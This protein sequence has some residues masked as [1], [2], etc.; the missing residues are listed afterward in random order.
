MSEKRPGLPRLSVLGPVLAFAAG[1]LALLPVLGNGFVD[2]DDPVY[3]VKN[4]AFRG[5]APHQ[6]AW[7]FTNTLQCVYQPLAWLTL[8]ADYKVWGM[9]PGGFHL[10]ALL[11][12]ALTAAVF[13]RLALRLLERSRGASPANAAGALVAALLFAVHP[14]RAE[15]VAWA[16]ERR[17]LV[18][19]LFWLLA[20][21]LYVGPARRKGRPPLRG[22]LACF[23]L[24]LLA[25]GTM[26][27][28]P[29]VLLALDFY[30]LRRLGSR[31][32]A[33]EALVEK[34]PFFAL[35]LVF[36]AIGLW[37]VTTQGEVGLGLQVW[38]L[39]ERAAQ[40]FYGL[41]FYAAKTLW[42]ARL[43][44]LY[45]MPRRFSPLSPVFLASY[46]SV[47]AAAA[48][49]F[50]LRRRFPAWTA[51]CAAYAATLLPVIGVVKYGPHITAD[52][53]SNLS[54]LGLLVLVGALFAWALERAKGRAAAAAVWSLP[55]S[56]ALV[57]GLQARRQASYWRDS[58]TLWRRAL[59]LDPLNAGAHDNLGVAAADEGRL[60]EAAA[61][62]R[63]AIA[64]DPDLLG[65]YENLAAVLSR[66]GRWEDAAA[67][68]EEEIRRAP[69]R[70][71]A[72]AR[73]ALAYVRA[74]RTRE[75]ELQYRL[76]LKLKPGD[77]RTHF[78]LGALLT[79][80]GR[81]REARKEYQAAVTIDPA[82]AD[83]QNN[84]G[85]LL[86]AAGRRREAFAHFQ[87]ALRVP[88]RSR[89]L[90]HFNWGNALYDEGRLAEAGRHYREAVRL[91]AGLLAARFNLA[92][93]LAR[94]GRLGEAQRQYR[95]LLERAPW[96]APARRNLERLER[97]TGARDVTLD[98]E[99]DR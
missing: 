97:L 80:L 5:F 11:L 52:R 71:P 81:L 25:K 33:R 23:A 82:Y 50:A 16:S 69:A 75:G 49:A 39:G 43:N 74:G 90:A 98:P 15:S 60:D 54:C 8:A 37:A 30:P 21:A 51:A 95:A 57:L 35:S 47:A 61:Q 48:S 78:N 40:I 2:W 85:L 9:E 19:D 24:A 55:L 93:T 63:R 83:A 79:R 22:P 7:M 91:D 53:Y 3:L 70:E 76:A 34:A 31:R 20:A 4:A 6:L 17:E 46:A 18:G 13:C 32:Q 1:F 65:A 12:H 73:L 44:Y 29:L 92:N 62:M 99:G 66:Q 68:C 10:T 58:L 59:E 26:L 77:A 86:A 88:G 64:I 36:G 56:L 94:G 89:A 27:S 72:H 28:L 14:L 38:T 67:V 84:L 42:P 87:A 45:E 96:Y 41:A